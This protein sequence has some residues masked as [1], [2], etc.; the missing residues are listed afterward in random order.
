MKQ[1]ERFLKLFIRRIT[2]VI[3]RYFICIQKEQLTNGYFVT[4]SLMNRIFQYL[5]RLKYE[6]FENSIVF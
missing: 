4:Y 1:E 5:L 2:Q 6:L 3:S